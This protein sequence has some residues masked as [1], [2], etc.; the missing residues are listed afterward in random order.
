MLSTIPTG[1]FIGN[2]IEHFVFLAAGTYVVFLWP[3]RIER[4]VASA[5]IT[6]EEGD[7]K[8]KKVR[9]WFGYF[10]IALVFTVSSA[11]VSCIIREATHRSNQSLEPT[12]GRRDDHV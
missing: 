3:R 4:Q 7:A 12:A 10:L 5:K 2:T 11:T 8:L 1:Q 9:P 6:S